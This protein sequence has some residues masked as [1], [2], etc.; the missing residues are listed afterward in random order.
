MSF[1]LEAL[2]KADAERDRGA[3]PDLYAQ[4]MLP[5]AAFEAEPDLRSRPWLWLVAGVGLA[6]IA[7]IGWQWWTSE[8]LPAVPAAATAQTTPPLAAPPAAPAS[9]P[10]VV[11][12]A[13]RQAPQASREQVPSP[14]LAKA[15]QAVR[16]DRVKPAPAPR[17]AV[18]SRDADKSARTVQA[19]E[20]DRADRADKAETTSKA[21]TAPTPKVASRAAP[22]TAGADRVPLL[23][24]LPDDVRRQVPA[25]KLGGLV[26][27]AAPASRM[28]LVNGDLQREGSTVAPGLTL[29]RINP[30][31][32]VFSLRGQRFEVPL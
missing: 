28:V 22:P 6:V 26:Y 17:V 2:K 25:L 11:A 7:A 15:P 5:E 24:E 31:S 20:V 27:S 16:T 8:P 4:G 19:D 12:E 3:V 1:I 29:E 21:A 13:D 18:A 9:T 32:A 30:K 23:T 14:A 10:A